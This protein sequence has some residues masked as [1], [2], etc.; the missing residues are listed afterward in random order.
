[1]YSGSTVTSALANPLVVQAGQRIRIPIGLKNDTNS[2]VELLP[3]HAVVLQLSKTG[4]AA[5]FMQGVALSGLSYRS[6][7]FTLEDTVTIAG[8]YA[9]KAAV[10]E[11]GTVLLQYS[12]ISDAS[13]TTYQS[14]I[15][16]LGPLVETPVKGV[17]PPL[18]SLL[19]VSISAYL[20]VPNDRDSL[21]VQASF[22]QPF[23]IFVNTHKVWECRD[24]ECD[25]GELD[26]GKRRAGD[27]ILVQLAIAR[28]TTSSRF[29][30]LWNAG[31][32]PIV[33]EPILAQHTC[34]SPL[35]DITGSSTLVSVMAASIDTASTRVFWHSSVVSQY[36]SA[37]L[38]NFHPARSNLPSIGSDE[39]S[40]DFSICVPQV[41]SG[42]L[43]S[44]AAVFQDSYGNFV[45]P[46]FSSLS[47]SL[48]SDDTDLEASIASYGTES[49]IT[50]VSYFFSFRV[51]R[52]WIETPASVTF[53]QLTQGLIATYY[54]DLAAIST[55]SASI[56]DWSSSGNFPADTSLQIW[57]ARWKG[58]LKSPSSG[59]WMLTVSKPGL[60]TDSVQMQ[61]GK[62]NVNLGASSSWSTVFSV[63]FTMYL[64][65]SVNYTHFAG[66]LLSGLTFSWQLEGGSAFSAIPSSAFF[67]ES[68]GFTSNLK[69]FSS[70]GTTVSCQAVGSLIS[71]ATAG[72]SS[73]FIVSAFDIFGNSVTELSH[74][75][76]R[77][78]Q[79][80]GC[81]TLF[82]NSCVKLVMSMDRYGV[83]VTPTVAGIYQLQIIDTGRNDAACTIFPELYV[84]PAPALLSNSQVSMISAT[85]ATAGLS[86]QFQIVSR[87]QFSNL[88]PL[89]ALYA[90][91][92]F[93]L[94]CFG[95]SPCCNPCGA[96]SSTCSSSI[97]CSKAKSSS[98]MVQAASFSSLMNPDVNIS[99]VP[100]QSGFFRLEIRCSK[101]CPYCDALPTS[102]FWD[103]TVKPSNH[104]AVFLDAAYARSF[105]VAGDSITMLGR[106]FDMFGNVV[107]APDPPS[108]I[109]CIGR[110]D[111]R[112]VSGVSSRVY[113]A[114]NF[115][116]AC[117]VQVITAGS[118]TLSMMSFQSTRCLCLFFF[119]HLDFVN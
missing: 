34:S 62:F 72:L 50:S 56:I 3:W 83:Q 82:E 19:N 75:K 30:L 36:C 28:I 32:H 44:L 58:F 97:L 107:L 8:V 25:S 59:T 110:L 93:E 48:V 78:S 113:L 40:S 20:I 4:L 39:L 73:T 100:T 22:N 99:F 117:I 79:I 41:V 81:N 96:S 6:S 35:S 84:Y 17:L 67:V 112:V 118:L 33:I 64:A 114:S 85:V 103:I 37:H 92:S 24:I 111:R 55:S 1:M 38:R 45:T 116:A 9:I 68:W 61:I 90:S 66:S 71:F 49:S 65:V 16:V 2:V 115:Y 76:L 102:T 101:E 15:V 60:S 63:S 21:L 87:D 77:L 80:S 86:L 31:N 104:V 57:R 74:I 106:S 47:I 5:E 27:V 54:R 109:D 98:I 14:P 95:P 46:D 29:S 108:Q 70:P 11:C 23:S 26:L 43:L 12:Q 91:F 119:Y 53:R 94:T 105:I 7:S 18:H 51:I 42:T 52:T 13:A 88:I 10:F 89:L 69:V